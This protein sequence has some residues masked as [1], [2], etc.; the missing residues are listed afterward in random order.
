MPAEL[1]ELLCRACLKQDELLVDIYEHVEE[2]QTDLCT[3]LERCGEIKVDKWDA[4]PK[5]LCQ[6][7]TKELLISAK[8]RDKCAATEEEL[9]KRTAERLEDEEAAKA[10][11]VLGAEDLV[12]DEDEKQT[13]R[14]DDIIEFDPSE[15]VE[16]YEEC[17]TEK[18]TEEAVISVDTADKVKRT[19]KPSS[20]NYSCDDCG[21]SF[22]QTATL[23]RHLGKVHP[24]AEIFSCTRCDHGFTQHINLEKHSCSGS[25]ASA[26]D[27][28]SRHR[29]THCGKC[30]QS[31]S[32]LIIHL[33]LHNGERP[34]ACDVCPKTFKTNGGLVTHQKRHL[35]LLEYECDYCGKGFVESSNLRRHIASMHTQERPHTCT[36]CQRT[37]SRVYLLE[38]HKRTHTGERPYAC[39]QCDRCFAQLSVLR[40]HERIH[41][42]ERRHSCSICQKTFSRQ[43]QLKKHQLKSCQTL[44]TQSFE[45]LRS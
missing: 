26:T 23:Q 1:S 18:P 42:G 41:T 9:R 30:M 45:E 31:A 36:V 34:F 20:T 6:E 28:R 38:L 12:V 7:C 17:E 11:N 3:L 10:I 35:K 16:F 27:M 8:F 24:D 21:A 5:Y 19:G 25:E 37:F 43:I 33:R 15:N 14:A 32:S 29:C 44:S 13:L 22:Q 39:S 2:Q 40:T 4:Y